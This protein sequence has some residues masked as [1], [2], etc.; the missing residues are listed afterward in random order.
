MYSKK[1]KEQIVMEL[2][3][4]HSETLVKYIGLLINDFHRAEDITQ[5]TFLKAYRE[6]NTF[7]HKSS[8]KTWLF[9]IARNL[10]YDYLRKQQRNHILLKLLSKPPQLTVSI[11]QAVEMSEEIKG[12]YHT[13]T[14]LKI[15]YREVIILRKIKEFSTKETAVIL[16]WSES[17][18]KSTLSRG[19]RELEKMICEEEHYEELS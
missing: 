12:L 16:G 18:V 19:L 5:E 3:E 14:H 15:T 1:E 8:F 9:T 6:M 10:A 11:E 13:L 2:Y 7:N 17:K 4:A